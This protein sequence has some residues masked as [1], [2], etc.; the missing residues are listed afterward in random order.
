MNNMHLFKRD[1]LLS[2]R[3]EFASK[4][5]KGEKTVELRR[6]FPKEAVIG[7]TA[8]I[9]S[10]SPVQA[11]VG[12]AHIE[13]VLELSVNQIWLQ[14]GDF[15]CISKDRF[16]SYFDKRSTGFA[17]ILNDVIEFQNAISAKHLREEFNFIPPQSFR[18]LPDEYASF[19]DNG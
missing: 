7:A 3:P 5:L 15:T 11:I 8:M 18:Y 17:I 4:I 6:R 10:S 14:Y 1:V 13:D 12:Y 9:Y 19:L 2:I 16:D